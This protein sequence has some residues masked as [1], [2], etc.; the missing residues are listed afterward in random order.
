MAT[1]DSAQRLSQLY[2]VRKTVVEML[3]DRGFLLQDR[4]LSR[5]KDEFAEEFGADPRREDLM[6]LAPMVNDPTDQIFVFFPDADA[7]AG[8]V[9]VSQ[10]KKYL[11]SMKEQGVRRAILV[12][13][14]HLTP[15]AKQSIND[16]KH[17]GYNFEQFS[18]AE[19]LVNITRHSLVPV[20]Q[21][22]SREEKGQLLSRYKVKEMQLPRIQS[23][24]PVARYMGLEKGQVV[25][26]VRPSETAG[27]YV[28]Y[29]YCI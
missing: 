15:F 23:S 22:L 20:H 26:I 3:K 6:I 2:R 4:E 10:V 21:L 16:A 13:E 5:T 11:E 14:N 17:H 19:L 8:K 27:R 9:G 25:R 29:R 12:V 28:T 18:E 24:D 1:P 7:N